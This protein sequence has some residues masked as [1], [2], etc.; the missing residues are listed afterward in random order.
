MG[1]FGE[2]NSRSGYSICKYLER[3]LKKDIPGIR[4]KRIFILIKAAKIQQRRKQEFMKTP[5]EVS[6][7][8]AVKHSGND[9]LDILCLFLNSCFQKIGN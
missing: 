2:H 5:A 1:E 4:M 8:V 7:S 9:Y 3:K 6:G